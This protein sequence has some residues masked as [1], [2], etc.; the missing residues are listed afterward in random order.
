[1][2]DPWQFDPDRDVRKDVP[3]IPPPVIFRVV[4]ITPPSR[5]QRVKAWFKENWK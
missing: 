3:S 5:A 4:S 2:Y 1:M